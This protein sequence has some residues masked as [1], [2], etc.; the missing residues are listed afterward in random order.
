MYDLRK[1]RALR[2]VA[3]RQSFSEAA[4]RLGYTQS[5]VS[6]QIAQLERQVGTQLL[7]RRGRGLRLTPAGRALVNCADAILRRLVD[8]EAELEAITGARARPLRLATSSDFAASWLPPVIRCFR[9]RHPETQIALTVADSSAAI[10]SIDSGEIDIAVVETGDASA[11]PPGIA[12]VSL[13]E[14]PLRLLA[15]C[16]HALVIGGT[17]G[18]LCDLIDETLILPASSART[19][20]IFAEL[21]AQEDV[22]PRSVVRVDDVLAV[23]GMVGA[24]VGIA[25]LPATAA[26]LTVRH[27]LAAVA[28]PGTADVCRRVVAL[29]RSGIE[30]SP[31]VAAMLSELRATKTRVVSAPPRVVPSVVTARAG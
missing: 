8:A 15:P 27:D 16:T 19:A 3:L 29:V 9:E 12:C 26:N 21:C 23:H 4:D 22:R 2:E 6:Q 10:A 17:R 31:A 14:D 25:V 5:A 13:F 30:R 20:E 11:G 7:D 24:G 1:L 28:L 18:Q